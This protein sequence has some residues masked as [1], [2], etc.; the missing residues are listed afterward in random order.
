MSLGFGGLTGTD[1]PAGTSIIGSYNGQ[2]TAG[3]G[4]G[5]VVAVPR[6]TAVTNLTATLATYTTP[7]ADGTFL[8]SANVQVTATTAAAMSVVCTYF[9]ETNT[10]RAQTIPFT[11]IAGTFLTSITNVTGVGPYEGAVL[12][13][14]CKASTT[15]IFTSTGTVTGITYNIQGTVIQVA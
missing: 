5:V 14:R 4:L 12:S 6:Q 7:A 11:Q 8:I 1:A 9:D 3:L 13:I 10:S 15:I 2:A